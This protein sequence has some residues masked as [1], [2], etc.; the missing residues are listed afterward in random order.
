MLKVYNTKTHSVQEFVPLVDKQVKMYGCG[1]TVYNLAHIGNLRAFVFYDLLARVLRYKGYN[2]T[3]AMNITDVDDKTI[4]D[5]AASGKS[6]KEFTRHYTEL[7]F[8]DWDT[9]NL[10][11]PDKVI[12]A[13]D[14]IEAM[15]DL[16]GRLLDK[17]YAYKAESGD[18]FFKISKFA[19]YGRMAGIDPSRLMANAD[20]RLADEY[21]KED[22]RDFALWK[23]WTPRDGDNVWEAPFGRGRPG[24]HIECS[25]M[26]HK[27]L[28][29]PFDIHVGG[30]DLVFPHHTNEIAQSECAYGCEFVKYW[31]HN[32]HITVNGQKM[33]KSLGNCFTL[34]QLLEKGYSAAAVRY[35]FLKSHYRQRMDFMESNLAG[36]QTVINR[37][38]DFLKRLS[39][40]KNGSGWMEL[41]EI[42][43]KASEGFEKGLDDDLNVSV[44][45]ASV[46]ELMNAVNKN[47]DKLSVSDANKITA[48]MRRFDEVLAIMPEL[49]EDVLESDL[50]EILDKRQAARLAKDWATADALK[51]EL[52]ARGI[53]VKDTPTGPIW[54][55]IA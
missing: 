2:L 31:M 42:L 51:A 16:V 40:V 39:D 8:K 5:S 26:S 29:Q 35:E 27:H 44:A 20:G 12:F 47:F 10:K 19:D 37:L 17:G 21:D 52:I 1:P 9:L 22:A 4:R 45:L 49:K 24:W 38:E 41:P 53:E 3:F 6:L 23:A 54:K 33:S 7:F 50:Q 43:K 25:A 55:R 11:R 13:T 18:V 46:F 32:E 15:I 30:I 36:N 14:E 34:T 48:L 28:G